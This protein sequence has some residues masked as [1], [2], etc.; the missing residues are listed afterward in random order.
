MKS[1]LNNFHIHLNVVVT[2]HVKEVI[3]YT[4]QEKF[5]KMV[6]KNPALKTLKDKLNL[7]IEF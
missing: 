3:A 4:D 7:E 1:K 2:E 6:E 5:K